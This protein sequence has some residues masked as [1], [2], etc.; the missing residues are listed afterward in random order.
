[1]NLMGLPSSPMCTPPNL[2]GTTVNG[3]WLHWVS[4]TEGMV[5]AGVPKVAA[6]VVVDPS[7]V[8]GC[9]PPVLTGA[10]GGGLRN[11]AGAGGGAPA[12]DV[13][14]AS[15]SVVSVMVAVGF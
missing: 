11:L 15:W 4:P 1:M 9:T 7:G 6:P 2:D 3:G 5:L 13:D 10:G 8:G 14:S 12:V